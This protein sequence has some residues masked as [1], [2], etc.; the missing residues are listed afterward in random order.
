MPGSARSYKDSRSRAS[1]KAKRTSAEFRANGHFLSDQ[2]QKQFAVAQ[3]PVAAVHNRS[4]AIFVGFVYLLYA[5][6]FQISVADPMVAL[7]KA[8]YVDIETQCL[9]NYSGDT[10]A[11]KS[12]N[13]T[14]KAALD[15][16]LSALTATEGER[17]IGKAEA[18]AADTSGGGQTKAQAAKEEIKSGAEKFFDGVRRQGGWLA[19]LW[20]VMSVQFS[21]DRVFGGMLDNP[22]FFLMVAGLWA[23]LVW[24]ADVTLG[25][26]WIRWP[27]KVLFGSVHTAATW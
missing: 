15:K 18:S 13:E 21:A 7:K 14:V 2:A 27:L 11:V 4:F 24:W 17:A 6:V 20:G 8:R 23:G 26:A 12:C 3:E 19:Y 9:A 16:K 22:A 25:A 10:A 1:S 5:W